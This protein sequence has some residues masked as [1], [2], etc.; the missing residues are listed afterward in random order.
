MNFVQNDKP[1]APEEL[2]TFALSDPQFPRFRYLRNYWKTSGPKSGIKT[3][4]MGKL[5]PAGHVALRHD[6]LLPHRAPGEY[7]DVEFLLTRC[8]A[9]LPRHEKTGFGQFTIDLPED[10]GWH[11]GWEKARSWAA[12]Y[13]V[14]QYQVPVILILHATSLSGSS[15]LPHVHA[16]LPPRRLGANGFGAH[17][18]GVCCDDGFELALLSWDD[19]SQGLYT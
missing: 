18:P 11:V 17:V 8:D 14:E 12:S 15:N 16:I 4:V 3:K 2:S 1:S 10:L 19:F 13:F 6:V 7:I 9:T 5:R